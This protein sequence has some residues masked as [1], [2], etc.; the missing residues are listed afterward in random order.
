[1]GLQLS[2]I[3]W[4]NLHDFK[5]GIFSIPQQDTAL[6]NLYGLDSKTI[7]FGFSLKQIDLVWSNFLLIESDTGVLYFSSKAVNVTIFSLLLRIWLLKSSL[8]WFASLEI[9]VNYSHN[10]ITVKKCTEQ[11]SQK[12]HNIPSYISV[13]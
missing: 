12:L 10:L 9:A 8:F 13:Q 7:I 5:W 6:C 1:M 11:Y 2:V 3:D 4:K